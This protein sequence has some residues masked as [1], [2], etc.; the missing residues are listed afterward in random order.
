MEIIHI[1]RR[2]SGAASVIALAT[3]LGIASGASGQETSAPPS[4]NDSNTVNEVV[5]V[6]SRAS[7]QSAIE[8]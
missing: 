8:R 4:L 6:G 5:V 1:R 3:A 2:A 7:Q